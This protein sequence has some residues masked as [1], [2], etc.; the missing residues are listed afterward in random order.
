[1]SSRA[2]RA[3]RPLTTH[4]HRPAAIGSARIA[5]WDDADLRDWLDI[6]TGGELGPLQLDILCDMV[7]A[8]NRKFHLS[9]YT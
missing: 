7:K 2:K 9:A 1:M 3:V 8:E 4:S 5:H 6:K